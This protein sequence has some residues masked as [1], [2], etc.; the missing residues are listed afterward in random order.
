MCTFSPVQ[1]HRRTVFPRCCNLQTRKLE[2][3]VIDTVELQLALPWRP[4]PKNGA[5][6]IVLTS[7]VHAT[8]RYETAAVAAPR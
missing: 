5:R 4:P 8:L 7:G 2:M 1:R 6:V 3:L